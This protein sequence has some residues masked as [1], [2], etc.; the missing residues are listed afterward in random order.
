MINPDV[1]RLVPTPKNFVENGSSGEYICVPA[2]H[3]SHVVEYVQSSVPG[4][5]KL[6]VFWDGSTQ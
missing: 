3:I 5:L 1:P 2:A 6:T 4:I